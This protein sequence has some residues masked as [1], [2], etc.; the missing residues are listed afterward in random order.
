MVGS[1]IS[2]RAWSCQGALARAGIGIKVKL[3]ASSGNTIGNRA[4]SRSGALTSAVIKVGEGLVLLSGA[5][6]TLCNTEARVGLT[7]ARTSLSVEPV[8]IAGCALF[9]VDV[10]LATTLSGV[11][12]KVGSTSEEREIAT[13]LAQVL[14]E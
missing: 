6:V 12:S 14:I 5:A 1:A 4:S 2:L 8:S 13:A 10:T 9:G 3:G 11:L 7:L